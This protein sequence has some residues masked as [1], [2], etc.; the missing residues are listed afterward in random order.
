MEEHGCLL[1]ARQIWFWY[2]ESLG[3][4]PNDLKTANMQAAMEDFKL[5]GH[6]TSSNKTGILSY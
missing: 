3:V 5:V 2:R 4:L 1:S 6:G